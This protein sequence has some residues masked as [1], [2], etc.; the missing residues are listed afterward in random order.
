MKKRKIFFADLNHI[1]PGKEWTIIPFPLNIAYLAAFLQKMLPDVFEVRLFKDPRKLLDAISNEKPDIAAFSNYIWNKNLQLEFAKLVKKL[2]PNCIVAMGGPNYN[3]SEIAWI[4]E[5][6]GDNPQIDFHING[7]GEV[8]LYNLA[9]CCVAHDFDLASVKEA[10]PAGVAFFRSGNENLIINDLS[11]ADAW[12]RLE[13]LNLDLVGGRLRDLNDVPSPYLTGLLDEFLADPNFCPIIETNRGCPYSCTFCNWGDMGKSKSAMFSLERVIAELRFIA[14]KNISKTPYLYLGDANFGLF[15]RDVE[16]ANLLRELKDSV[17]FPQSVYLYFAKNSSEKVVRIAEILKDM[18]AISLSR[19][20]QN[21]DVL[22]IIKRS[23]INIDTFNRLADLAKSLGIES[24]VELIYALPGESKKS[25]YN[26]VEEVMRQNVD[27]VHMFP[28][29]LLDGSEMGTKQSCD[30]FGIKGEW[31]RIDGCAGV[32]GPIAAIEFEKIIVQSNVMSREDYFEIRVFH[33][34]QNIFLGTKLYKD[35]E[36]LLGTSSLFHLIQE[37]IANF[38]AAPPPFRD[39]IQAFVAQAKGELLPEPPTEFS[40]VDV[41][42]SLATSLKLNPMYSAKLLYDEG[43][44]D[45]F[46]LFL[47]ERILKIGASTEAQIDKVLGVIGSSIYPFD[48]TVAKYIEM[49]FDVVQFSRRPLSRK[50]EL[51]T[52]ELD[53]KHTFAYT[54]KFTYQNFI[55]LMPPTMSLAEKVYEVLLHHTHEKFRKTVTWQLDGE[56]AI[57]DTGS[58]SCAVTAEKGSDMRKI[59]LEGGWVY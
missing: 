8:K 23:N 14:E 25:F 4:N 10:N 15:Q 49:D 32:Y 44:R 41:E 42:L 7:E 20:T 43:V 5:F 38:G 3:F 58:E 45:A 46:H 59:Q 33:F 13:G 2:H 24:E 56:V 29:M 28:A 54:R 40:A 51:P 1:N 34:L 48:G 17:G 57:G 6:A 18:T 36:T 35:V 11:T 52:Y 53:T 50:A 22:K 39:L 31:R 12:H 37:I 19:Q 27:G 30:R 55:D 26:G 47:K 16:I 21:T 9:A